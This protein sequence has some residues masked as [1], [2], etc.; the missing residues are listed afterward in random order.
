[1]EFNTQRYSKQGMREIRETSKEG[2]LYQE[3]IKTLMDF[4]GEQRTVRS[5]FMVASQNQK[6]GYVEIRSKGVEAQ[7]LWAEMV[8]QSRFKY[9]CGRTAV[10][11]GNKGRGITELI[12]RCRDA[13]HP[14]KALNTKLKI[15]RSAAEESSVVPTNQVGARHQ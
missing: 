9:W 1:M 11:R 15:L 3:A 13:Q 5:M 6:S 8:W 2:S 7:K 14:Q 12:A 4:M 10:I